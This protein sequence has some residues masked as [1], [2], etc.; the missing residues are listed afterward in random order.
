MTSHCVSLAVPRDRKPAAAAA[1]APHVCCWAGGTQGLVAD[2][3]V[4]A[5]KPRQETLSI[6]R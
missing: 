4:M 5:R 2:T 1:H 3:L 6:L